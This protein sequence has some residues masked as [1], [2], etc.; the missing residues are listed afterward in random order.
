MFNPGPVAFV[1]DGVHRAAKGGSGR[2]PGGRQAA[3]QERGRRQP[4]GQRGK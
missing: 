1:T 2:T 4:S 3:H